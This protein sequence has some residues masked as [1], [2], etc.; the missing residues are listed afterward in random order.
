MS[1][2]YADGEK[3]RVSL[4]VMAALVAAIHDFGTVKKEAR[5]GCPGQARA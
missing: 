5:R 1:I 2:G 4:N 3:K